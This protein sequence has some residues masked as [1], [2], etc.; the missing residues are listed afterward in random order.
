MLLYPASK[1]WA[2][3]T[4]NPIA[5][6]A[7]AYFHMLT[8]PFAAVK[9]YLYKITTLQIIIY[10]KVAKFIP[11]VLFCALQACHTPSTAAW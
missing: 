1:Q 10:N 9:H 6:T 5:E 7:G 11:A 2:E 3:R 4:L 8:L